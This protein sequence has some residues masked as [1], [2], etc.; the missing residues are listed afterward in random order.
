M[1]EEHLEYLKLAR[2]V[3]G[4]SNLA[5][6]G[7]P[8]MPTVNYRP[9]A[10]LKH[11]TDLRR[12]KHLEE[13]TRLMQHAIQRY[14]TELA[15][16]ETMLFKTCQLALSELSEEE[17]AD[18]EEL[19]CLWS[20]LRKELNKLEEH[21]SF[22]LSSVLSG[23]DNFSPLS[24]MEIVS[25]MIDLLREQLYQQQLCI[26]RDVS[27]DFDDFDLLL[28]SPNSSVKSMSTSTSEPSI[29]EFSHQ[30]SYIRDT[31][32]RTQLQQQEDL[33]KSF[34]DL[35]DALMAEVHSEMDSNTRWLQLQL[36]SKENEIQRLRT[37]MFLQN[38]QSETRKRKYFE[39]DV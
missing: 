10:P 13:E 5:V 32:T 19:Q 16:M 6:P 30:I 36:Q 22:R 25:S 1:A 35:K 11:W 4:P 14:K 8:K 7:V 21:L 12:N 38:L 31:I 18:L 15:V 23:N 34:S 2:M 9:T 17:R 37:E 26:G 28:Q 20:E 39:S 24:A 29:P 33:S 3:N 27:Y